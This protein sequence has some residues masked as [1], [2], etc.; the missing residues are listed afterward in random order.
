MA[1]IS[2]LEDNSS[3]IA[4]MEIAQDSD[5]ETDDNFINEIV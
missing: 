5:E 3:E 2:P 1:K 4:D